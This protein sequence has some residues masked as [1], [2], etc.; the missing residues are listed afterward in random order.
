MGELHLEVIVDRLMR[1]FKVAANVGKPTVAYRE[2]ITSAAQAEGRF[3]RQSGGR[4]QYGHVVLRLEPRPGAG[5]LEFENAVVGGAIPKEYIPAV[6]RGLEEAVD[7]GVVAG[8]PVIGLKV[9]LLDGSFHPVD[10]SEMAFKIAASLGFQEAAKQAGPR[11]LEPVMDVEVV[12]PEEF[13]G[14]VIADL[15]ARRGKVAEMEKRVG[16]QVVQAVVPLANMFGYATDLRSRT[17]GRA[18]FTMQFSAYRLVPAE[19][20]ARLTAQVR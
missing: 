18:T 4:G 7:R 17:Q 10:S 16:A 9:T 11:L 6:Q 20:S 2:T 12:T 3:E 1:E 8:H 13:L 15:S 19:V 14:E 5:A